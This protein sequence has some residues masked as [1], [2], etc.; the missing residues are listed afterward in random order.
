MG[1]DDVT[2]VTAPQ[3]LAQTATAAGTA[4][5][6]SAADALAVAAANA[7]KPGASSTE[8]KATIATIALS[9]GLAALKVFAVVPGPWTL[10]AGLALVAITATTAAYSISRGSVKKAALAGAAAVAAA[11]VRP[12]R[13]APDQADDPPNSAA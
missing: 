11:A 13:V 2:K 12:A 9:A 5:A 7:A 1:P 8:F 4:A 10:P 3:S 6:A